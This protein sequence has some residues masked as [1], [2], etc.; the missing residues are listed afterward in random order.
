MTPPGRPAVVLAPGIDDPSKLLSTL[1]LHG[2]GTFRP[3][4]PGQ[5]TGGED[6]STTNTDIPG[7]SGTYRVTELVSWIQAPG[8]LLGEPLIDHIGSL[9]D[10]RAGLAVL[11]IRYSDGLHGVLILSCNL[12]GTRH[13]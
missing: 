12:D 6:W 1:T 9:A 7:S 11:R 2:S 10:T 8:T 5:V 4:H 13:Q 3:G